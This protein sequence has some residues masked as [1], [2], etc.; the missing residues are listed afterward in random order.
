MFVGQDPQYLPPDE[1]PFAEALRAVV[2]ECVVGRRCSQADKALILALAARVPGRVKAECLNAVRHLITQPTN[3]G[4]QTYGQVVSLLDRLQRREW[5]A[6]ELRRALAREGVNVSAK[7]MA[8]VTGYLVRVGRFKRL[9]R[10]HYLDAAG[11]LFVTS[12]D[13]GG[14]PERY[15]GD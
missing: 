2:T 3:R 8:D 15:E 6:N 1:G 5:T 10:G 11:N 13:L 12:D 4:G 9:W 7:R 14:E